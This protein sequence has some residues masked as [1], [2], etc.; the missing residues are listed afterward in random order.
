MGQ[1]WEHPPHLCPFDQR[2]LEGEELTTQKSSSPTGC[3]TRYKRI[4]SVSAPRHLG[5]VGRTPRQARLLHHLCTSVYTSTPLH[6]L[7]L[8][9][10]YKF[11]S[12]TPLHH[13]HLYTIYKFL[14]STPL[15]HLHLYTIYKFLSSTPLH[16]LHLYIIYTSTP[17]TNFC[18]LRLYTICTF[19][20][21]TP[22]HH[23]HLCTFLARGRWARTPSL[24]SAA[25]AGTS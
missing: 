13:L 21:S 11:M 9:I 18:H 16:H 12:S 22:L 15:H 2:L 5:T 4:G 6:H 3:A 20:S 14:S 19:L 25:T 10:I 24:S 1:S 8:Y 23:L 17:S 7:H